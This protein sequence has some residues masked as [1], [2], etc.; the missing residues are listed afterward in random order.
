MIF[1]KGSKNVL[2][3]FFTSPFLMSLLLFCSLPVCGNQKISPQKLDNEQFNGVKRYISYKMTSTRTPSISISVAKDGKILWEESL[4]WANREK[5]IKATPKTIYSLASISK[6]MTATAMMILVERGKINI[7]TP[8]N[9]YLGRIKLRAY[10]GNPTKATVARILHHTAGLPTIWSF[11]FDGACIQRPPIAESIKKFAIITCE[12]GT[13]FEYSNL[14]YGIAEAIIEQVSEKRFAEFMK[15]EVFEPLGM[16][17]SFVAIDKSQYEKIAARYLENKSIS[18]FF[19][20]M[21]RG[22]G[23]ICASVQD[24]IRFGMFHLK[25]YLPGNQMIISEKSIDLMQ[26]SRDTGVPGSMNGYRVVNHGGGMPGVSSVLM[27]VPSQNLAIAILSNGTYIDLSTIG[28]RILAQVLPPK[29]VRESPDSTLPKPKQDFTGNWQGEIIINGEKIPAGLK[30]N[31]TGEARLIINKGGTECLPIRPVRYELDTLT[32]SFD[33]TLSTK[34]VSVCRHKVFISL[35]LANGVM[36]G[37]A[38][39]ISYRVEVYFLPYY[40]ILRKSNDHTAGRQ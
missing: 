7:N 18:P 6:P 23:G 19:E 33:V 15:T 38:A 29:G 5:K 35:K 37:Y 24:L 39:A 31:K 25:N 22:G 36:S 11:Y 14:G 10:G 3:H 17:R 9:Q 34:D 26:T 20:V 28:K 21:S 1:E 4:G 32:G 40:M 30:I 2:K 12:P 13:A 16:I 27:L 8:A